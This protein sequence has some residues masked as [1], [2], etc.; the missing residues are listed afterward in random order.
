MAK[1][2][3]SAKKIKIDWGREL[4]STH[5]LAKIESYLNTYWDDLE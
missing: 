5:T 3:S 4:R 1:K 2:K